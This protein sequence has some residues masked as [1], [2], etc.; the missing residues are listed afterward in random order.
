MTRSSSVSDAVSP[1]GAAAIPLS[2][3]E[4]LF[5][6]HLRPSEHL[7]IGGLLRL[8]GPPP[9][10]ADV[11][12]VVLSRLPAW[13]NLSSV[14]SDTRPPCWV[15]AMTIDLA[16]Q[17]RERLCAPGTELRAAVEQIMALP[18][19]R[20]RPLWELW[21][22]HGPEIDEWTAVLKA[23]HTVVDGTSIIR[24]GRHLLSAVSSHRL[25]S[26]QLRRPGRLWSALVDGRWCAAR[27][28]TSA[29]CSPLLDRRLSRAQ[30]LETAG[31]PGPASTGSSCT[32][33]RITTE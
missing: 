16:D 22:V 20:N 19:V 5:L 24:L 8:T 3:V 25:R 21:I 33:S 31:S 23:H 11:R 30:K 9:D 29:A 27:C 26:R 14:V 1:A 13:P 12:E 4:H 17:V 2:A 28:A 18:L 32:R 15:P 10:L 6:E 7:Q